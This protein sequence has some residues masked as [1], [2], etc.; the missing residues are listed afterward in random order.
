MWK[1]EGER[2]QVWD[3]R[4]KMKD[5]RR[6]MGGKRWKRKRE[7]GD[8]NWYED[9]DGDGYKTVGMRRRRE[10]KVEEDEGGER[11]EEEVEDDDKED[12]EDEEENEEDD[13][14]E[15]RAVEG[16]GKKWRA[17]IKEGYEE[18]KERE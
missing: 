17:K 14:I 5:E 10:E 9:K 6:K 16:V 7:R 13:G 11:V 18:Q 2:C 15:I 1:V 8:G 12:E 4:W 3:E